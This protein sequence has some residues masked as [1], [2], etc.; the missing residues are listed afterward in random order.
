MPCQVETSILDYSPLLRTGILWERLTGIQ[1][2]LF[3][4]SAFS[5]EACGMW[6]LGVTAGGWSYSVAETSNP[7]T[8]SLL[9][10]FSWGR[11]FPSFLLCSPVSICAECLFSPQPGPLRDP[12]PLS[13]LY[14]PFS[15]GQPKTLKPQSFP[16]F[17]TVSPL[18]ATLTHWALVTSVCFPFPKPLSAHLGPSLLVFPVEGT[19]RPAP[20]LPSSFSSS[21]T[22]SGVHLW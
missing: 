1:H 2:N 3:L 21:S 19:P 12:L 15:T 16:S 5:D 17:L 14:S 4:L 13:P 8:I 10:G 7:M 18:T 20:S 22:S 11:C 9:S 6:H